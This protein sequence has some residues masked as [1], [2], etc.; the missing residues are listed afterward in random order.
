[1]IR[2]SCYRIVYIYFKRLTLQVEKRIF[3][4]NTTDKSNYDTLNKCNLFDFE[5]E[6]KIMGICSREKKYVLRVEN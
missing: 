4:I 1:M 3:I 6:F 5:V 2:K